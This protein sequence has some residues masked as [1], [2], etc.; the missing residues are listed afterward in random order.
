VDGRQRTDPQIDSGDLPVAPCRDLVRDLDGEA[1]E[2]TVG[3]AR[4]DDGQ[5]A[6]LEPE[7]FAH[8]DPATARQFHA[9]AASLC[10]EFIV[11]RHAIECRSSERITAPS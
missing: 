9:L 6:P 7:R 4:N 2:P 1:G 11:T 10:D 3:L 5:D 8:A